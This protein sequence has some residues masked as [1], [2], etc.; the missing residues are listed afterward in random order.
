M[1][2]SQSPVSAWIP[3]TAVTKTARRDAQPRVASA[4]GV[5]SFVTLHLSTLAEHADPRGSE[6]H[7]KLFDDT[8]PQYFGR[9]P[10]SAVTL[11]TPA[12]DK[13]ST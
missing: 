7:E 4:S 3:R 13:P 8:L 11:V 12:V 6:C 9:D 10:V 5:V 2:Q 1:S